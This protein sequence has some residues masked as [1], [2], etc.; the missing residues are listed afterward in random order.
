M[1]DA[2]TLCGGDAAFYLLS[3]E[4]LCAVC[5]PEWAGQCEHCM[6]FLWLDNTFVNANDE[7]LCEGCLDRELCECGHCGDEP[8]ECEGKNDE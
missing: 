7:M 4:A 5:A 3:N 1:A 8:F 2:C 6:G